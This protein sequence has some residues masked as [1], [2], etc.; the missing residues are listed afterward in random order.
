[1]S[2]GGSFGHVNI[3][4]AKLRINGISVKDM[5]GNSVMDNVVDSSL[6]DL[7]TKRCNPKV[8][9]TPE[10][11]D[12]FKDLTRFFGLKK[13]RGSGKQKLLDGT[14]TLIPDTPKDILTRLT[15]FYWAHEVLVTI[16]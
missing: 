8:E 6:I 11:K 2:K 5:A 4:P 15:P 10:A 1:M 16:V 9:Y 14:V 13:S 7:L 3:D 12:I